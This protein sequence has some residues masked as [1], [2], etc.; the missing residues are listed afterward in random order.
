MNKE[1]NYYKILGIEQNADKKA[2]KK[3]YRQLARKFHPDINP[4]NRLY[5]DKFKEIGEAYSILIDDKKRLQYDILKGFIRTKSS[6]EQ[7]KKQASKAYSEKKG[8][9]DFKPKKTENNWENFFNKFTKSDK[10]QKPAYKEPPKSEVKKGEDL[11]TE[12]I[13]T[14]TEAHNGTVRKV[15]ILRTDLCPKC[16]GKKMIN[17]KACGN[18]SGKGEVSSHKKLNV[19]IP[20]RVKHGSKIRITGEGNKGLHGGENGD[21][22]LLV[23][24]I[25]NSHFTFDGFHVRCELPITPTE[26]ALGAEIQVPSIDGFINMRIPP[27][28]S[29]GQKFKLTGEGLPEPVSG[30]RGDQVVIIKIEM[31]SN[32]TEKEKELYKELAN[33]RKFNPRENII[34]EKQK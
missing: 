18:C 10:K 20:A 19:K 14:I 28:T 7:A 25:K 8:K 34:F 1:K 5:E 2:M 4:G 33:L 23:Y 17:S 24:I 27:E 3:A 16:N 15:N 31:P 9:P 12:V 11:T 32:L 22:Y 29:A 21:L 13:L 26:A 30:K 6:S